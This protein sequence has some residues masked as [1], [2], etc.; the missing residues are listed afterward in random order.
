MDEGSSF[1][2]AFCPIVKLS[3]LNFNLPKNSESTECE[4]KAWKHIDHGSDWLVPWML[5]YPL[6]FSRL[7]N[8]D[9]HV[10]SRERFDEQQ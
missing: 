7:R 4:A 1:R 6:F 3:V 5:K 10:P 8:C 2:Y 9:T